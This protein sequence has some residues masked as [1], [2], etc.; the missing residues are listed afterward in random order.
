[1]ENKQDLEIR[2]N[3]EYEDFINEIN[4]LSKQ[5]IIE[6]SLE[7]AVKTF[8]KNFLIHKVD[9]TDKQIEALLESEESIIDVIYESY[10]DNN[11]YFDFEEVVEEY[12]TEILD[13]IAEEQE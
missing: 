2:L 11:E 13:Y 5:E 1:M 6:K 9:L 8:V 12:V 10:T 7:I 4:Q 3:N